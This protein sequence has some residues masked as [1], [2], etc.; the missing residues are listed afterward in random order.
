MTIIAP[1]LLSAN[2]A[3]LRSDL[4]LFNASKAK[5]LHF[6]VMDGHFVPNISFGTPVLEACGKLTDKFMDVH[7]MASN[8]AD[9]VGY[10]SKCHIDNFTFHL[11]ACQS[12]QE[13]FDLIDL[14]HQQGWQAGISIKPKT[15]VEL[16]QPYLEA[17]D[18]VLVMSVEPGFGGQKF[19]EE[20]MD[21]GDYL[22]DY[23]QA[24]GLNY[25]IEVNCGINDDTCK[26]AK[27]HH[28]EVLVAGSYCFNHPEGFDRAVNSL[29][30]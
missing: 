25:H 5:W 16:L 24:N 11:E 19:M 28:F 8:P 7:V 4:V 6:D 13:V 27:A 9:F 20:V 22:V 18:L 15:S 21:K 2:F 1:S 29:L 14:I 23:K 3:D 26:P 30:E 17:V 10:F 12:E